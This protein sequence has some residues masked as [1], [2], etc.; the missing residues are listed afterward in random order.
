MGKVKCKRAI[1]RIANRSKVVELIE[2]G[3]PFASKKSIAKGT[4]PSQDDKDMVKL[5]K[6][7]GKSV[8]EAWKI[9]RTS[10]YKIKKELKKKAA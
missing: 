6:S 8:T 10:N 5:L 9:V 4:S 1:R 2:V 3:L 7:E